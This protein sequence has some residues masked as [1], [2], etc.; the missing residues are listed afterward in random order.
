MKQ[1]KRL[2]FLLIVGAM[3][4]AYLLGTVTN[5]G[6]SDAVFSKLSLAAITP[7]QWAAVE[8]SNALL[9]SEESFTV[10]LPLSLRH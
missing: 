4:V 5:S 2:F 10:F 9:L 6:A 1:P 3:V 8:A 7:Q